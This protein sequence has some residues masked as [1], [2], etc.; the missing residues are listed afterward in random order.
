MDYY[1]KRAAFLRELRDFILDQNNVNKRVSLAVLELRFGLRYGF[2]KGLIIKSI[3]LFI[4]YG[5]VQLDGETLMIYGKE[6][7]KDSAPPPERS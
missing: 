5:Y 6:K 2:G 1:S 7:K 3:K 4:P